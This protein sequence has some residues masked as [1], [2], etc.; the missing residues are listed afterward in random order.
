M[1]SHNSGKSYKFF[2]WKVPHLHHNF[3]FHL[4]S[5]HELRP[6]RFAFSLF[7]FSLILKHWDCETN[8]VMLILYS[9]L[10]F[11]VF[12]FPPLFF[13]FFS[14][15]F[16]TFLFL[17]YFGIFSIF[18]SSS[19]FFLS[20]VGIWIY[21][22]LFIF[23]ITFSWILL[24]CTSFSN[25]SLS[26]PLFFLHFITMYSLN[27]YFSDLFHIL[28]LLYFILF[29]C[30]FLSFPSLSLLFLYYI[31]SYIFHYF[32]SSSSSSFY[33]AK[34]SINTQTK[35]T[36]CHSFF[37]LSPSLTSDCCFVKNFCWRIVSN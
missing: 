34:I 27:I 17:Q 13:S 36:S 26:L 6:V 15:I 5:S 25:I 19:F 22:V 9:I 28:F 31:L 7:L 24:F 3:L 4:S 37:F 29:L 32:I 1:F 18:L 16:L 8:F 23:F 12:L 33:A 21:F 10:F 20:P 14:Q 30:G 2:I 11:F 35:T